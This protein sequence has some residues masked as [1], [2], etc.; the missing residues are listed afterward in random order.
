M[1]PYVLTRN[2]IDFVIPQTHQEEHV[3]ITASAPGR[4]R[5]RLGGQ[6]GHGDLQGGIRLQQVAGEVLGEWQKLMGKSDKFRTSNWNF[7]R[8]PGVVSQFFEAAVFWFVLFFFSGCRLRQEATLDSLIA[9]GIGASVATFTCWKVPIQFS[10]QLL[11]T[12][13]S[14]G[15]MV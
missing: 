7:V 13:S 12:G 6:A 14:C 11:S 1:L 3:V 15:N 2:H 5:L 9:Q 4:G 8:N 10:A